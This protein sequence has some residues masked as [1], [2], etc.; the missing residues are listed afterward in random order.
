MPHIAVFQ[1]A[2][3]AGVIILT[4]LAA[5]GSL[6]FSSPRWA[7]ETMKNVSA[8]KWLVP[9]IWLLALLAAG[10]GL[11]F[12]TPGQPFLYTNHRGETVM[13]HGHGLVLLRHG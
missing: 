12:E 8:L 1:Q 7:G 9:L 6:A 2:S 4:R 5:F 3:G 11:F 13:I 10:L